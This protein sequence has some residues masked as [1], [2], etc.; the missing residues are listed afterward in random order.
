VDYESD[1]PLDM[2]VPWNVN[3][4]FVVTKSCCDVARAGEVVVKRK[5]WGRKSAH[6]HIE[7]MKDSRADAR[8][9]HAGVAISIA[10]RL[11]EGTTPRRSQPEKRASQVDVAR[12][13]AVAGQRE[14]AAC[15]VPRPASSRLGRRT[16]LS[17]PP[18][19]RH[20]CLRAPQASS[21]RGRNTMAPGS[22][23][24]EG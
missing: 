19:E 23:H 15:L 8:R 11:A 4:P 13:P 16:A 20:R 10:N 3:T 14:M 7:W 1:P 5:K 21:P 2:T 24:D 12:P 9:A 18:D 6:D 17:W 22:N